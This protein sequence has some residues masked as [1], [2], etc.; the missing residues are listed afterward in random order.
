MFAQHQSLDMIPATR[1]DIFALDKSPALNEH[2]N[3]GCR[4]FPTVSLL[5]FVP[6]TPARLLSSLLECS[7][8][9]KDH[10]DLVFLSVF[11][12]E[13]QGLLRIKETF[14]IQ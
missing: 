6:L 8:L 1:L 2:L 11:P 12:S 13:P 4:R 14:L 7:E 10:E 3:I 9:T 5:L